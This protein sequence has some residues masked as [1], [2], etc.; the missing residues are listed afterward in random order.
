MNPGS[1]Y[2]Y[3]EKISAGYLSFIGKK[4]KLS[5]QLGIRAENSA[6]DVINLNDNVNKP[7]NYIN[8]FPSLATQFALNKQ[9]QLAFSYSKRLLR[10]TYSQLNERPYYFN[11]FRQTVGN[12]FL[13]PS[14]INTFEIKF[15]N[16]Q[17]L[18]L[19]T[20]YENDI[21]S[22]ILTP[23]LIEGVTK[24]RFLNINYSNNYF[25]DVYFTKNLT[26]WWNTITRV[27]YF[28]TINDMS[29]IEGYGLVRNSAANFR[30][31][32][33]FRLS[34]G[35]KLELYGYY[36]PGYINGSFF[37]YPFKRIDISSTLTNLK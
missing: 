15:I 33:V 25:L 6:I 8:I 34:K 35:L 19:S 20:S 12:T 32:N 36:L 5:Y 37:N 28:R 22:I 17:W 30:S 16:N 24:Y 26:K 27:Q 11:P 9:Q 18:T 4:N 29:N 21:N 31:T 10:P 14:Y 13:I 3:S 1:K 2:F 23:T 7:Q